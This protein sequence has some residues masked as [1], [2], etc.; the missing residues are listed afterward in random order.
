MSKK[1]VV[2]NFT[3]LDGYFC[4]PNGE[5]DWFALSDD[6]ADYVKE[7][8][9]NTDTLLFGRK[10][11]QQMAAFWPTETAHEQIITDQMNSLPKFVLSK[12]LTSVEWNNSRLLKGNIWEEVSDLK[13]ELPDKDKDILILGSGNIVSALTQLGL[14]DEYHLVFHP[15]AIGKGRSMFEI[16]KK[17]N[18]ELLSVRPFAGGA[19]ALHYKT[20][21]R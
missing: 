12:T 20:I 9:N 6:I 3:T 17:L 5:L 21:Q 8:L 10:T 11:Y 2:Y 14:V 18:L 15:V 4:G 1:L 13:Q 16:V 7:L 19:V